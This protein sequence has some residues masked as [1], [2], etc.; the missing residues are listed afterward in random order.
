MNIPPG[1]VLAIFCVAFSLFSVLLAG[2]AI[3]AHRNR[4]KIREYMKRRPD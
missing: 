4:R 2:S 3:V 1:I